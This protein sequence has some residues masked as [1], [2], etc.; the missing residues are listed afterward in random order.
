MDEVG[1]D[2]LD[3]NSAKPE[4]RIFLCAHESSFSSHFGLRNVQIK[5]L[6]NRPGLDLTANIQG[7]PVKDKWAGAVMQNP[8]ITQQYF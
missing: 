7:P 5:E 8:L 3:R 1:C 2:R 4:K 6:Q